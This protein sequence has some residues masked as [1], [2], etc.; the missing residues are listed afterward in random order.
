M[1]Q[2]GQ[3]Q[4]YVT[5]TNGQPTYIA[6]P[7]AGN[8]PYGYTPLSKEQYVQG[9]KSKQDEVRAYL[10]LPIINSAGERGYPNGRGYQGQTYTEG[11]IAGYQARIDEVLAGTGVNA[12]GYQAPGMYA[13]PKTAENAVGLYNTPQGGEDPNEAAV[14]AGTM[15]RVPIGSG[16][17]YIPTGSPAAQNPAGSLQPGQL[18]PKVAGAT[19]TTP[20]AQPAPA[21]QQAP[22]G[23]IQP[24]GMPV[25]TY[26]GPSIVDYL[27]SIG[28]PSDITSRKLLAQSLGIQNYRGTAQ[29]NTQMLDTLRKSAPPTPPAQSTAPIATTT[30]TPSA[31]TA[32]QTT[33]MGTPLPTTPATF[34]ETYKKALENTGVS[35]IKKA[36]DDTQN[37]YDTL[38][39][40][41]NDEIAEVG[42]NPWISEGLRSR[43]ITA[44]QSRYEGKLG[45][46]TNKLKL[47]DSLHQQAQIEA[48]FLAS[49]EQDQSQFDTNVQMKLFEL[50]QKEAEAKAKL[51]EINPTNFKEVQGGLVDVSTG[52]WVIPP[53]KETGGLTNIQIDNGRAVVSS[54]EGSPVIKNFLEIQDRYLNAK[55]YTGRGD[56]AT[57]I[58]TIYDLMKVLDPTS[59][60]REAE[61]TTGAD[62]SGNIFAGALAR[63]NGLIDPKGG[64]VSESAKNNISQV[65]EDR[66]NTRKAVYDNF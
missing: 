52:T 66:Y 44:L 18:E 58:A 2:I 1:A 13:G 16:W 21:P 42:N 20:P 26:T 11:D 17:G 35:S 8:V 12:P 62:K 40:K 3:T 61:Y 5:Y 28:K 59:V 53:K 60:V 19:Q 33:K 36:F 22:A 14:R 49:G 43:K 46:L 34:T 41:L 25:S 48:K 47:Y 55:T 56:G 51:L 9:L 50:A 37:A 30:A 45:I 65:I 54:F 23:Q 7:F 31:P 39:N 38:Q 6:M 24:A 27:S 32:P 29:E 64:F 15:T 10:S 63:F 57:D 4:Y